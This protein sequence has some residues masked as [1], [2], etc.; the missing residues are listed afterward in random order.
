[1]KCENPPKIV[2][3]YSDRRVERDKR[4]KKIHGLEKMIKKYLY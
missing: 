3:E 4:T 2:V 1:M